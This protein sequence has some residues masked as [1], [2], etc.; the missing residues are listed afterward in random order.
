MP[1]VDNP[2]VAPDCPRC[3]K[4]LTYRTTGIGSRS[5]GEVTVGPQEV[6][7]YF[8][9]EHG[10]YALWPDGELKHTPSGYRRTE[11]IDLE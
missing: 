11:L 10:F 3:G 2:D 4:P 6:K 1:H 9:E 7:Q 5:K 8:C